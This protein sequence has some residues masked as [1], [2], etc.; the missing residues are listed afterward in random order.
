MGIERRRDRRYPFRIRVV[1]SGRPKDIVTQTEDVSFNGILVRTDTPLLERHLVRLQL[2]LPPGDAQLVVTGMV[3]RCLR[4]WGG[5]PP[6]AGIKFYG[7][8][9]E[10]RERWARF[11]QLVVASSRPGAEGSEALP[12][13][14]PDPV[15]GRCPGY[16]AAS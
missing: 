6:G 14:R 10:D 4:S 15:R 5:R 2:T 7:L 12:A 1:L 9:Q 3:A 8:A 13:G 11:I 16:A